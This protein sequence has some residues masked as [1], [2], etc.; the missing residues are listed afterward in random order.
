MEIGLAIAALAVAGAAG[1]FAFW[2]A[3]WARDV[4]AANAVVNNSFV[5]ARQRVGELTRDVKDR[6]DALQ[7]KQLE[8]DRGAAALRAANVELDRAVLAM[9]TTAAKQPE[10]LGPAVRAQ[11][12]RLRLVVQA[13]LPADPSPAPGAPA[14]TGGGAG[15]VRLPAAGGRADESPPVA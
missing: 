5:A 4:V 3:R 14:A 8:I 13:G 10:L 15:P 12:E 9:A 1:A 2:C 7:A 11:L 6:D